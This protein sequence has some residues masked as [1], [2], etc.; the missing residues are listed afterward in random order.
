MILNKALAMICAIHLPHRAESLTWWPANDDINGISFQ[1]L[2][3]IL[4]CKLGHIFFQDIGDSGEI[5][6]EDG[7]RLLI[8]VNGSKARQ[9]SPLQAKAETAATAKKINKCESFHPTPNVVEV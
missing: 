3:Q 5:L 7:N 2:R 4:R 9:S 6:L 1:Q 8:E